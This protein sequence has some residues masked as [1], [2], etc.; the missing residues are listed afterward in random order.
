MTFG[1]LVYNTGLNLFL[2]F[3][4]DIDGL[5]EPSGHQAGVTDSPGRRI[6]S[7]EPQVK[8]ASQD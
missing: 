5:T 1:T 2:L 4:R 6:K 7:K 3:P 8:G